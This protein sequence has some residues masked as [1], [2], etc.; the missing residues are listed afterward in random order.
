[1]W[2]SSLTRGEGAPR[3]PLA[4]LRESDL[5]LL[6]LPACT[7][8]SCEKRK[9]KRVYYRGRVERKN[10]NSKKKGGGKLSGLSL[11]VPVVGPGRRR[12][13]LKVLLRTRH[14]RLD[15][16]GPGLPARGADLAVLVSELEG[17]DETEGLVHGPSDGEVVDRD[18]AEDP[19]RRDD[20]EAAEGDAGVVALV[21]GLFGEGGEKDVSFFSF[22]FRS[23][24]L[25]KQP[26]A[27]VRARLSKEVPR[28]PTQCPL[29]TLVLTD[30]HPEVARDRLGDVRDQGVPAPAQPAPLARRLDP[31]QVR[32]VGVDGDPHDLCADGPELRDAVGEGDDLCFVFLRGR[33]FFFFR[34]DG[35]GGGKG[36]ARFLSSE[37]RSLASFSLSFHPLTLSLLLSSP[38]SSP[39]R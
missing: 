19:G 33:F 7:R 14:V 3:A 15:R 34:F 31:G 29:S 24:F 6:W 1:M 4:H 30:E 18:L 27:R 12:N 28:P 5:Y 25:Q 39:Y 37:P 23:S 2:F 21:C 8:I 9:E 38:R 10:A 22:F 17:L 20:E 35:G 16:L 11:F 32:E 13:A 36:W 26:L